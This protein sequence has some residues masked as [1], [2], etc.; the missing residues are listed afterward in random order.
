VFLMQ[1]TSKI[2]NETVMQFQRLLRNETLES[3]YEDNDTK[4]NSF[5]YTFLNIYEA[6]F[7]IKYKNICKLRMNGVQKE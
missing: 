7:P 2:N 4:F 6:S 3:V 5:P 1:R